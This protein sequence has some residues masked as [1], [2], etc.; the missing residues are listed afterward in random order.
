[1]RTPGKPSELERQRKRA[2]QAVREGQSPSVV[3]QVLGVHRVTVQR[4]L[5]LARTP[6]RL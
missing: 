2:V 5:R 6:A 3:A 4:W 1:M